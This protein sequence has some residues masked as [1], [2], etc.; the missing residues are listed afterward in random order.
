[1]CASASVYL[2]LEWLVPRMRANGSTWL[3][4]TVCHDVYRLLRQRRRQF[5][6]SV[7]LEAFWSCFLI[8]TNHLDLML[9]YYNFLFIS[10][11]LQW[12][13]SSFNLC[14]YELCF[15]YFKCL[16]ISFS[17]FIAFTVI[18]SLL[19]VWFLSIGGISSY[20]LDS[21]SLFISFFVTVSLT[22][23]PCPLP[24]VLC[25]M[26]YILKFNAFKFI[27]FLNICSLCLV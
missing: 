7:S 12:V 5:T 2:G 23:Y 8:F 22:L 14:I 26:K 13:W 20:V 17:Y 10:W 24:F 25:L 15:F 4:P 21:N 18:I 1:M 11:L 16:F 27:L 9:S 6:C 19:F 3:W